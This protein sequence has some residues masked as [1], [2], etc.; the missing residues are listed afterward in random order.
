[1]A[2]AG[3]KL[4]IILPQLPSARIT[5]VHRG[6]QLVWFFNCKTFQNLSYVYEYCKFPREVYTI[7]AFKYIQPENHHGELLIKDTNV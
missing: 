3:L 6:A 4:I 5:G 2:Q 7:S 1:M